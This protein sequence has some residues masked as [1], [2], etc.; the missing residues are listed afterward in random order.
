MDKIKIVIVDPRELSRKSL[1]KL[2]GSRRELQV[3]GSTHCQKS[4]DLVSTTNPDIVLWNS[5]VEVCGLTC[6]CSAI[7]DSIKKLSPQT[8]VIILREP[9]KQPM[10]LHPLQ[11][12]VRGFLSKTISLPELIT[13]ILSVKA[14]DLVIGAD[15]VEELLGSPTIDETK[16]QVGRRE[17]KYGLSQ[18]EKDTLILL[19]KG[20]SNTEIARTLFISKHTVK[21]HVSH[22]LKKMN[23]QSRQQA[24]LLALQTILNANKSEIDKE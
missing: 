6:S 22:I 17:S 2:M 13:A 18:R 14:G 20:N 4:V 3:L 16:K 19:A 23:L 5:Q 9:Q 1:E 21:V 24:A 11:A 12:G 8:Q 7:I 15:F 10:L